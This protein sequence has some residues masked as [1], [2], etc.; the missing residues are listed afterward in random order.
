MKEW[1]VLLCFLN[2]HDVGHLVSCVEIF[3]I[4]STRDGFEVEVGAGL[5]ASDAAASPNA[6]SSLRTAMIKT[7]ITHKLFKYM[8]KLD[9]DLQLQRLLKDIGVTDID[10]K[11]SNLFETEV[12]NVYFVGKSKKY[13]LTT[14]D[15]HLFSSGTELEVYHKICVYGTDLYCTQYSR[16]NA[17]AARDSTYFFYNGDSLSNGMLARA[18]C[19]FTINKQSYCIADECRYNGNSKLEPFLNSTAY[20]KVDMIKYN[21]ILVSLSQITHRVTVLSSERAS[22]VIN[23]NNTAKPIALAIIMHQDMHHVE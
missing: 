5:T 11:R 9:E 23:D 2:F 19:Y 16:K 8:P 3:S 4:D 20:Y 1:N 14:E 22:I 6:C 13:V 10:Y 21:R 7:N 15:R 12:R 17:S 18:V